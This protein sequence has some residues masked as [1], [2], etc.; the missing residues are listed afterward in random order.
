MMSVKNTVNL[1]DQ[2]G[3]QHP[4]PPQC[5]QVNLALISIQEGEIFRGAHLQWSFRLHRR[6]AA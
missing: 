3:Q 5:V 6:E 2:S 4:P 1:S